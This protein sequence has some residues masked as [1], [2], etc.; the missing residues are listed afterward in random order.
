MTEHD[1]TKLKADILIW[2]KGRLK[3]KRLEHTLRVEEMA[4]S[5]AAKWG[6]NVKE[7]SLAALLHDNAKYVD[8]K[9]MLALCTRFFGSFGIT[10]EYN[11]L[12]HAFA[13]SVYV[14]QR[15]P[16]LSDD[17]VK[18]VCF[19][20]TGRPGMS[21][22]EKIIYCADFAEPGRGEIPEIKEIRA[23]LWED[24]NAALI[25]ILQQCIGYVQSKKGAVHPLTVQTLAFYENNKGDING[26][27]TKKC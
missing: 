15:Y 14:Q 7:A 23:L 3:P 27:R 26:K 18:A 1:Y 4:T 21:V 9:E 22:L 12:F 6:A 5:L 25:R 20:T 10:K 24:L 16:Q 11:S 2:I 8:D 19:H 13:G 17:I